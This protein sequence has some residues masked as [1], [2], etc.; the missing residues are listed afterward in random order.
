MSARYSSL[1]I[2]DKR[3]FRVGR[4]PGS[5]QMEIPSFLDKNNEMHRC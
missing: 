5:H 1:G 2:I 4:V 3:M